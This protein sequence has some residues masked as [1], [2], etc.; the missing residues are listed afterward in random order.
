[1]NNTDVCVVIPAYNGV[2]LLGPTLKSIDEQVSG[3]FEVSICDDASTDGSY[4][5]VVAW[6]KKTRHKVHL[7]RNDENRGPSESFANAAN[8]STS[9]YLIAMA[10]DDLLN[11]RHVINMVSMAE[12]KSD[13]AAVMPINAQRSWRTRSKIALRSRLSAGNSDW[14]TLVRLVGGNSFFSPGTLIRRDCWSPNFQHP[15]NLQAQ[16]FEMWLYLSLRGRLIQS[17]ERVTY[18]DHPNNLHKCDPIEHDLDVG[19]TLRRFLASPEFLAARSNLEYA[20]LLELDYALEERL[21]VHLLTSPLTF[22]LATNG[23]RTSTKEFQLPDCMES[24]LS[25]ATSTPSSL[26]GWDRRSRDQVISRV[27]QCNYEDLSIKEMGGLSFSKTTLIS[28]ARFRYNHVLNER[29]AQRRVRKL[30][31]P[32]HG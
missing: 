29:R 18:A 25:I 11:N 15:A 1:M 5:L 9:K 10:Q 32:W 16:D 30:Q 27:K 3:S 21:S 8:S 17:S 28:R 22:F 26:E 31:A 4:D 14:S 7:T 12:Q 6:A 19:L 2:T 20:Q 23:H 13:V 24:A